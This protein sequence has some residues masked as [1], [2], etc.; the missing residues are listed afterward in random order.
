MGLFDSLRKPSTVNIEN[1][2]IQRMVP[3]MKERKIDTI[4]MSTS[5]QCPNCKI[6]NKEIY[7]MFGWNKKYPKLPDCLKVSK[8]PKCNK[9]IGATMYFEEITTKPK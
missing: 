4:I 9:S 8:C 6:Y 5:Q 7:S 3:K 2:S 1:I